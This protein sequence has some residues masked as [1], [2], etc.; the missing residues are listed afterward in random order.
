MVTLGIANPRSHLQ[1]PA[2]E[3]GHIFGSLFSP[4]ERIGIPDGPRTTH[5][6]EHLEANR[7]GYLACCRNGAECRLHIYLADYVSK[8]MNV[9]SSGIY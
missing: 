1:Y 6:R 2:H 3:P 7:F 8:L 4:G 5:S 9:D